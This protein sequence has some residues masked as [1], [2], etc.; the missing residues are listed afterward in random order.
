MMITIQERAILKAI[1][2]IYP[3]ASSIKKLTIATGKA[4]NEV[5]ELV[6][7]LKKLQL[8]NTTN[9]DEVYLLKDGKV[10]M[11][12]MEPSERAKS[13]EDVRQKAKLAANNETAS[14]K[15]DVAL[16]EKSLNRQHL[17]AHHENHNKPNLSIV[18]EVAN[19]SVFEQL[20]D[21]EQK[22]SAPSIVV[23]SLT[24]KSAVLLQLSK[25]LAPDISEVLL[26]VNE[27]LLRVGG[28]SLPESAA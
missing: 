25:I 3:K 27:D 23:E 13:D 1:A 24:L 19:T 28:E 15:A 8:I 17:S 2:D 21:L 9:K 20:K 4:R 7:G 14:V 6:E 18:P 26:E 16:A 22:L 10:E 5:N 12:V 11:A